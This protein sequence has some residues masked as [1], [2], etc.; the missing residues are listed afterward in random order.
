LPLFRAFWELASRR[1][2]DLGADAIHCH[3][4][5]AIPAGLSARRRL[6]GQGVA[7]ALVVDF[8]EL[9]RASRMVPQRGILG[10]IARA[11]V[12]S[13]ERRAI[14][15]ASLVI[16]ANEGV[17][18]HYLGM[19]AGDKALFVPNA[20]DHAIFRPIACE[21]PEHP[22]TITFIGRKRYART[23]EALALAIQPYPD[24]TAE[25]IGDG[26]DAARVDALSQAHE[27]VTVGGPVPYESIPE[28]YACTDVVHA[29]Y[30]SV[31]GNA[32]VCTP[33]KVLEAMAC[34]KPVL[35]SEGTWVGDW[36]RRNGVGVAVDAADA[37][38]VGEALAALRDDPAARVRMGETGRSIV[39]SSLNWERAAAELVSAY[40]RLER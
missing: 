35:V 5:D 19:G 11:L 9:Y 14:R 30:D 37:N 21:R 3:D 26:P 29:A 7:P 33:G 12:D 20:P 36:V 10:S 18:D 4:T 40:G 32:R 28:R 1:A 8:H 13:I 17:V 38:K 34:A 27:R 16:V 22:F 6:R 2:A 23:L 15:E 24:M 39:E 31:V 25:L